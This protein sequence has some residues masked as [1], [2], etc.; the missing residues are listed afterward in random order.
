MV[1]FFPNGD[2]NDK[3]DNDA[4][5]NDN[6]VIDANDDEDDDDL[7]IRLKCSEESTLIRSGEVFNIS[8]NLC[9]SSIEA[10]SL[11]I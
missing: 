10:I 5:G 11:M 6:V 1:H 2:N 9:S 7:S 3:G 8:I 4:D